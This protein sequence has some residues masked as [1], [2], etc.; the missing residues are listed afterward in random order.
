MAEPARDPILRAAAFLPIRWRP[1]RTS[2]ES[3]LFPG[4]GIVYTLIWNTLFAAVFSV[5]WILFDPQVRVMRVIWVNL[6]VAN[7]I[8][9]FIHGCVVLG[10][11]LLGRWLAGASFTARSFFYSIVSV[12]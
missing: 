6:V 10:E 7:C 3:S 5:F 8:G 11:R 2:G 1:L 4:R 12:S 9:F